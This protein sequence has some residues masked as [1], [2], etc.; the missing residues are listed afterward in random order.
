MALEPPDVIQSS[1]EVEPGSD[2]DANVQS[3]SL[4]QKTYFN[5]D[6]FFC[7]TST[8]VRGNTMGKNVY[9]FDLFYLLSLACLLA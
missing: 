8:T 4:W 3:S 2:F 7:G 6:T 9:L 1:E 5:K